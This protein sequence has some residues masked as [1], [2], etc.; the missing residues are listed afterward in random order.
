[1]ISRID[2]DHSRFRDIVRG[3]VRDNLRKYMSRGDIIAP[4]SKGTVTIPMPQITIPRFT[5]GG[6]GKGGVGQGDGEPGDPID[7]DEEGEQ[8]GRGKAGEG[9]EEAEQVAHHLILIFSGLNVISMSRQRSNFSGGR[10]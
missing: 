4:S 9:H 5:F 3:K 6:R 8:K 10:S 7:G 1:M 2:Q